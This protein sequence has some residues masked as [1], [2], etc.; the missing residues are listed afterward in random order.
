MINFTW[1]IDETHTWYVMYMYYVTTVHGIDDMSSLSAF[2]QLW[3]ITINGVQMC[4]V[5]M[6]KYNI[7]IFY[8]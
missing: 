8:N 6:W 7:S 1:C 4:N 2:E 3:C 5:S